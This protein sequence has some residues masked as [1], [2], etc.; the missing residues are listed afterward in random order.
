MLY[1][2]IMNSHTYILCIY[3]YLF[4]YSINNYSYIRTR[5]AKCSSAHFSHSKIA[6]FILIGLYAI[7]ILILFIILFVRPIY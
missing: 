6:K 2:Y 1:I 4:M 5:L 7:I 3:S